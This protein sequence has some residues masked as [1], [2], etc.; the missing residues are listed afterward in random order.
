MDGQIVDGESDTHGPAVTPHYDKDKS[1]F[2]YRSDH[3]FTEGPCH[4][5]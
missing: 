2:C 3:E 5:C 4:V 1:T